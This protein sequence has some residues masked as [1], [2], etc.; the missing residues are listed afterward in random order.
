MRLVGLERVPGAWCDL[1]RHRIR[2][3][4]DHVFA[5]ERED[6]ATGHPSAFVA[7]SYDGWLGRLTLPLRER[8]L[9]DTNASA[10]EA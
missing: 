1:D 2:S 6:V 9:L 10:T 7:R 8:I 3:G 4:N 5:F